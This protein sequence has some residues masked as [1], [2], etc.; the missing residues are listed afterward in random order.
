M[1]NGS[2]PRPAA[3][4]GPALRTPASRPGR[5]DRTRAQV[6]RLNPGGVLN[7]G[8]TIPLSGLETR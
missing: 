6:D 7:W 1:T 4:P 8:V 3:H 5:P 2:A